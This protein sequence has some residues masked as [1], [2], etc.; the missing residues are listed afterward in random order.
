MRL[1]RSL[2]LFL[3]SLLIGV[4]NSH[5]ETV[6]YRRFGRDYRALEMGNTGITSATNSAVLYY[7]PAVLAS[8]QDWWV[9]YMPLE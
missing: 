2:F 6:E 1:R 8:I 3:F 9:K 7:N 4:F 5:V